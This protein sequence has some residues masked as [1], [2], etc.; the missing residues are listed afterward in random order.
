MGQLYIHCNLVQWAMAICLSKEER[1]HLE[2][3]ARQVFFVIVV[4]ILFDQMLCNFTKKD[5]KYLL[6]LTEKYMYVL[7]LCVTKAP[8]LRPTTQFHPFPSRSSKS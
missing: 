7:I 6:I 3:P 2:R 1:L 5:D 8:K 4:A